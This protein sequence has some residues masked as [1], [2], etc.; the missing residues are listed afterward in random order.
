MIFNATAGGFVIF[1][2]C[3]AVVQSQNDWGVTYTSASICA[4]T[5][6][7]VKMSCRYRHPTRDNNQKITVTETFWFVHSENEHVD[8]TFKYSGRVQHRCNKNVCTL[9]ISNVRES[10][11]AEYK[12]RFITNSPGGRFTGS[13]GVFLTVSGVKNPPCTEVTYNQKRICAVKG[14]SVSISCSYS[15][16]YVTSKFW[17]IP[18]RSYQWRSPSQAEDL[19]H[20][21]QYL[22]RVWVFDT[23]E[24]SSLT[25]FNLTE[26]DSAEY[27]FKFQ[28]SWFEWRSDAD[29]VTLTVTALQVQVTKTSPYRNGTNIQL[30]CHSICSPTDRHSFIWFRNGHIIREGT[31]SF[32]D[33]YYLGG[34]I[35]CA[36]KQDKHRAPAVYAPDSPSVWVN[37][38]GEIM[39]GRSV[40]LTCISSANPE[41][42]YS[43]YT[44]NRPEALQ[45]PSKAPDFV[46]S[47]IQPSDSG[48]YYCTAENELGRTTSGNT[49]IDV[50][51]APKHPSVSVN[52][53]GEIEEGQSVNLTCI[54]DANP[55]ATYTWYKEN[56]TSPPAKKVIYHFT[57]ISRN[58]FGLYL[59]TSENKYG[60]RNSSSVYIDVQY[61]PDVPSVSVSP[62]GELVEGASVNMTCSSDANPA[63]NFTWYKENEDS[64]KASGQ[65]FTINDIRSEHGGIYYCRAQNRRGHKKSNLHLI[66]ASSSVKSAVATSITVFFSG[67][68]P[69]Y[70][71]CCWRSVQKK[72]VLKTK[73]RVQ[74]ETRQQCT[75]CGSRI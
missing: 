14:S 58:D 74:K 67:R 63:A 15:P 20:D 75:E 21:R 19:K 70:L 57:T 69:V 26:S 11:S 62:S 27:R 32:I 35:S 22:N 13:P 59:C 30:R 33:I 73:L 12:F 18:G 7:T 39:M 47:S 24:Q 40:K 29:G 6:S 61:A 38:S 50:K 23:T 52:P 65:M 4:L 71:H 44:K 5:G 64:P 37:S 3:A 43:W 55:A 54:S 56:Q 60:Q 8:R 17:Y 41:A 34:Q 53:P 36:V 2:L 31:S 1:I 72:E 10:D 49:H 46:I 48:E 68:H 45:P 25:I 28:T 66:I 42:N 51:Y 9:T 16:Q